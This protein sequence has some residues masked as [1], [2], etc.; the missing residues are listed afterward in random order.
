M[1]GIAL[2]GNGTEAPAEKDEA[3]G[4]LS[5]GTNIHVELRRRV[6]K[7][8]NRAA[9]ASKASLY[10]I[11]SGIVVVP[12]AADED[13]VF[14]IAAW[15]TKGPR[16]TK[17]SGGGG[18]EAEMGGAYV[19]RMRRRAVRWREESRWTEPRMTSLL[20]LVWA[21]GCASMAGGSESLEERV[22]RGLR[23]RCS[24]L[25]MREPMARSLP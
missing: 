25:R 16:R 5:P 7:S 15:E 4:S 11:L 14:D 12:W 24:I 17:V 6:G 19:R 13:V 22:A 9:R 21:C 20:L 10:V 23:S 2:R 8:D 18:G 3:Q 1:S